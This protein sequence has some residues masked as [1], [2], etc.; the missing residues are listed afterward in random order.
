MQWSSL[1]RPCLKKRPLPS[2]KALLLFQHPCLLPGRPADVPAPASRWGSS[3]LCAAALIQRCDL[4]LNLFC[5]NTP[6]RSRIC[7]SL[8]ERQLKCSQSDQKD[9]DTAE[10]QG[11]GQ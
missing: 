1:S 2:P 5:Q 8:E 7:G 4:F 9:A 3:L 10:G 6:C 11:R